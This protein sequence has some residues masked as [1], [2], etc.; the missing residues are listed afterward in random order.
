MIEA[1]VVSTMCKKCRDPI[2]TAQPQKTIDVTSMFAG[3]VIVSACAVIV[4]TGAVSVATGAVSVAAGA[5]N[6]AAGA[7]CL[8]ALWV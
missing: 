1:H 8:Q 5:V 6:V 7:V 2:L 4:A 3:A